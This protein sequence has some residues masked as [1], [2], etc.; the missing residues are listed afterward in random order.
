MY[1]NEKSSSVQVGMGPHI[2]DPMDLAPKLCCGVNEFPG[3]FYGQ[4]EDL[5]VFLRRNLNAFG[6]V[7]TDQVCGITLNPLSYAIAMDNQ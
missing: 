2:D 4:K 1:F 7:V 6:G 3:R 5:L